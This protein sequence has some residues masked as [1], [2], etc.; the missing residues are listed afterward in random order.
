MRVFTNCFS[1]SASASLG[2]WPCLSSTKAR[3]LVSSSLSF[4]PTTPHS[5]TAACSMSAASTSAGDRPLAAERRLRLLV[6]V[7]VE[8][9]AR[10][11]RYPQIPGLARAELAAVIVDD[12]RL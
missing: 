5:S 2:G 8:G 4:A 10:V 1:S 12:L 7:P 9:A 11:T 3:G 6:L